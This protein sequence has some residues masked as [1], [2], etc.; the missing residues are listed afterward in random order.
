MERDEKLIQEYYL[1][2]E[3]NKKLKEENAQL[4]KRIIALEY[5]INMLQRQL[6]SPSPAM[7]DF[8]KDMMKKPTKKVVTNEFRHKI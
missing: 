7:N 8:V 3:N 1:L 4:K 5:K 2:Q 6:N